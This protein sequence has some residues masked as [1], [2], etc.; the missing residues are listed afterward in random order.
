MLYS[1]VTGIWLYVL[2]SLSKVEMGIYT[3]E[4]ILAFSGSVV[5]FANMIA[6]S[7]RHW[8]YLCKHKVTIRVLEIKYIHGP[9]QKT[10]NL[11]N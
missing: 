6:P 1:F 5:L 9:T 8:L 7:R 3:D 4:K 2:F 10:N 11:C